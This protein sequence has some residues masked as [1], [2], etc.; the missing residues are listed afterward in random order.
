MQIFLLILFPLI[1]V[2]SGTQLSAYVSNALYKSY[3]THYAALEKRKSNF[4][5]GLLIEGGST[6]NGG[7]SDG[8]KCSVLQRYA[9]AESTLGMLYSRETYA[10]ETEAL[11][12]KL[13]L[14]T[15]PLN[16][17]EGTI[18]F[19]GRYD[20]VNVTPWFGYKLPIDSFYGTFYLSFYMPF[21]Y[22]AIRDVVAID[23]TSLDGVGATA[24]IRTDITNDL[25][26]YL[27]DYGNDLHYFESLYY[28]GLGDILCMIEWKRNFKQAREYLINVALHA[29][30]GV[31]APT[32]IRQDV[33]ILFH[34]P[35]G[36]NGSWGIPL[37]VAIDLEFIHHFHLGL[38]VDFLSLFYLTDQFRL[39]TDPKQSPLF[40]PEKGTATIAPGNTWDF[41]LFGK[42][43]Q[44]GKTGFYGMVSYQFISHNEDQLYP[45]ENAFDY[46]IVNTNP[47]LDDWSSHYA[48][49]KW[50]YQWGRDDQNASWGLDTFF[51]YKAPILNKRSIDLHLFGGSIEFIF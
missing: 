11:K 46:N 9:L 12:T 32:G 23:Q 29:K 8:N 41:M 3:E 7:D 28:G 4:T 2:F 51:F 33:D 20:Q 26:Q 6:I 10:T 24:D 48:L 44:I 47:V 21:T 42:W 30:A 17:R 22:Q 15:V 39:K 16:D 25:N 1:F 34:Q 14:D 49:F 45:F 43:E 31:S 38:K 27:R 37:S 50:G 35:N 36:N 5:T 19:S 40:I 18:E 13:H